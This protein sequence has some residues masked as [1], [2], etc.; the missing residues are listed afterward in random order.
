M[1]QQHT[2]LIQVKYTIVTLQHT[3]KF[4]RASLEGSGYQ[5]LQTTIDII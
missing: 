3:W 5:F 4:F 2:L 1:Q